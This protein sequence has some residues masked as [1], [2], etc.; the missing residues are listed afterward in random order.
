M[1]PMRVVEGTRGGDGEVKKSERRSLDLFKLPRRVAVPVRRRAKAKREAQLR[2]A[3]VYNLLKPDFFDDMQT[4]DA[5]NEFETPRG[6]DALVEALR[7]GGH[8]VVAIEADEQAY[9][10][11]LD[12]D[13]DIVFNDAEGVTVGRKIM[14]GESRESHIPAMLEFLGIPYVGS[15]PLTLALCLD[16][17]KTKEVLGYHGIPTP[18]FQVFRRMETRLRPDLRFPLIVKLLNQGSQI[19]LSYDN[20]VTTRT[21][22]WERVEYLLRT[23]NQPVLIEEFLDGR[24]FT[25]PI[26]GNVNPLALPVIEI[27]F[28]PE[29][30]AKIQIYD[31]EPMVVKAFQTR[32]TR[33]DE[34]FWAPRDCPARIPARLERQ[35]KE[36]AIRAYQALECRDWCRVDLRMDRDGVVHV[37][38]LNPI[39]G[40]EPGYHLPTSAEAAGISYNELINRILNYALERYGMI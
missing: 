9:F 21:K 11:F 30:P 27:N 29:A 13:L 12:R 18:R 24:E 8:E 23:Y 22:L 26:L 20:V 34:P 40:I 14:R 2:V 35:I 1:K 10:R 28:H 15:G 4:P 6:R 19:G 39:A 5:L 37:I 33:L 3:L 32:K 16:K 25:V 38:E 17:A 36:T 7:A 31:H